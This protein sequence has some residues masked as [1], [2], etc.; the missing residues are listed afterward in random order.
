MAVYA[1]SKRQYCYTA[2]GGKVQVQGGIY[3]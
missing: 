3:E 2:V 1:P